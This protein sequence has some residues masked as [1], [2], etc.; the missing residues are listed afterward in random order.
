M[1]RRP[2]S[3]KAH[4]YAYER[5]S[6]T[7]KDDDDEVVQRLLDERGPDLLEAFK[8]PNVDFMQVVHDAYQKVGS[9]HEHSR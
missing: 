8:D 9:L 4:A 3:R 1:A 2:P 5:L 6:D 7:D